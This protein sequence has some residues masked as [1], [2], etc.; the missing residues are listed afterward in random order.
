MIAS[1]LACIPLTFY[2]SFANAYLN[3]LHINNAGAMM[4]L[5][6]WAELVMLLAMPVLFRFVSIRG[7]LLIGLASWAL[8][9]LLLGYGNAD[10][11]IW[12][13]YLAILL[14]GACYDFFF[15]AGQLYTD[16][17]APS[18]LRNSA[19]GFITFATYGIG[20]YV[21]SVLSGVARD[22]FPDWQ[23]FWM[24]SAA[25]SGAIMLLV[26]FFFRSK[27]MI[28]AGQKEAAA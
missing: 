2:Y 16:Q 17:E 24:S 6:Q 5:G 8:R 15:V 27:A 11:R 18:H 3:D 10:S 14:H 22:Y 13:F 9:Y 26:L 21:G 23:S 12:M 28:R 4:T 20:M 25:M 1:I 7:V 19:Q